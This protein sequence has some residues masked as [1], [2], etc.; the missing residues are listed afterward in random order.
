[1]WEVGISAVFQDM[2]MY[3]DMNMVMMFEDDLTTCQGL[4]YG[5]QYWVDIQGQG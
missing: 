1:M 2:A 4:L 5:D 3:T